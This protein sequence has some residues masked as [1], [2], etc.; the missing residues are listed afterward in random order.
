[1][2]GHLSFSE[3]TCSLVE[4]YRQQELDTIQVTLG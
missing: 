4:G 1:M 2:D 3:I